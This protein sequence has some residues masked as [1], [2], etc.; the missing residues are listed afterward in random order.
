MSLS[1][2]PLRSPL[3]KARGLGAAHHG[4]Q[5]WWLQRMS[6][7]A[8]I[9]LSIWFLVTLV[10]KLIGADRGMVGAWLG[11][12]FVALAMAALVIALFVH[13]RLGIQ[14]IIEDYVHSESKKI[15]T[16]LL[17][18]VAMLVFGAMALAAIAH[19]NFFGA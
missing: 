3:K 17:N 4:V 19:L 8:L 15:A 16:L 14:V 6:A 13:A 18:N 10:T 1:N 5:H 7:L 9:P 2:S 12:P 11:N